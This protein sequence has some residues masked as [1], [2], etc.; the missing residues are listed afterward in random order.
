M[1]QEQKN[2][3]KAEDLASSA[4]RKE[5]SS[6]IR[7]APLV[8]PARLPRMRP[9][10]AAP[11]PEERTITSLGPHQQIGSYQGL[12]QIPRKSVRLFFFLCRVLFCVFVYRLRLG[13]GAAGEVFMALAGSHWSTCCNQ[14]DDARQS[15][16]KLP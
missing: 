10:T 16:L 4:N 13:E 2:K 5:E 12:P 8:Y 1:E 14:E 3:K 11:L 6:P 15:R 7:T 9:P